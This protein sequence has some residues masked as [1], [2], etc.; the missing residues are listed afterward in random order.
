MN[1]LRFKALM[2]IVHS[3]VFGL[4]FQKRVSLFPAFL[5]D[6]TQLVQMEFKPLFKHFVQF[7]FIGFGLFLCLLRDRLEQTQDHL[8]I[9]DRFGGTC[10]WRFG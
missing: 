5:G 1:Y 9:W 7:S 3:D 4:L 6:A 8:V 2:E 10:R